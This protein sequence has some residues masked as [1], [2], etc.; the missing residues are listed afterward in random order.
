ML[1]VRVEDNP[2]VGPGAQRR[3]STRQQQ[4]RRPRA[5][6]Q[7]IILQ[8]PVRGLLPPLCNARRNSVA[9]PRCPA[10]ARGCRS[11]FSAHNGRLR[12][13]GHADGRVYPR[14]QRRGSGGL[15]GGRPVHAAEDAAAAAGVPRDPGTLSLPPPSPPPFDLHSRRRKHPVLPTARR[16]A[17]WASDLPAAPAKESAV[18]WL[19]GQWEGHAGRSGAHRPPLAA[20]IQNLG[21]W[22]CVV[23][24]NRSKAAGGC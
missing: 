21:S 12:V 8:Q 4:R 6:K 10:P 22:G 15:G 16:S 11:T 19:G 23:G 5:H 13:R 14:C 24:S 20:F 1:P 17:L 9:G 18:S 3:P 2:G 7:A